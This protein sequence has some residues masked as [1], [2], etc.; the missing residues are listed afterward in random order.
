LQAVSMARLDGMQAIY[1]VLGARG[2]LGRRKPVPLMIATLCDVSPSTEDFAAVG[3]SLPSPSGPSGALRRPNSQ[4]LRR[5]RSCVAFSSEVSVQRTITRRNSNPSLSSTNSNPSLG[6]TFLGTRAGLRLPSTSPIPSPSGGRT[7]V[8][9]GKT[10]SF[11]LTP[12][13]AILDIDFQNPLMR[14]LS[15]PPAIG[16][17]SPRPGAGSRSKSAAAQSAMKKEPAGHAMQAMR[18]RVH[19]CPTPLNTSYVV[20]P[21]AVKYGKHPKCFDFNR[22]GEMQLNDMGVMEEMEEMQAKERKKLFDSVE[23]MPD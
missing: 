2:S 1:G 14:Q 17:T 15:R 11:V 3:F 5:S 9:R 16:K 13:N 23:D 21:Y 18:R 19:F 8:L 22:K 10:A 12:S 6:A 7:T 20:T 4:T